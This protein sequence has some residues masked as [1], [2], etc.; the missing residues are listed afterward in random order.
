MDRIGQS[1][2]DH[3]VEPVVTHDVGGAAAEGAPNLTRGRP[4]C[5]NW[6]YTGRCA[7][8]DDCRFEHIGEAGYKSTQKAPPAPLELS[9]SDK[10]KRAY[11]RENMMLVKNVDDKLIEGDLDGWAKKYDE[12][13][14]MLK[15]NAP[16]RQT[17]ADI[18]PGADTT[19]FGNY[20]MAAGDLAASER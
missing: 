9:R 14:D 4:E 1:M 5:N 17:W 2:S 6:A 11:A 19:R 12:V 8:A 18:A 3:G 20:H 7:Y 10:A 15:A 16:K 13:V